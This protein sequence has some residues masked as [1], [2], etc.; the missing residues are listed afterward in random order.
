MVFIKNVARSLLS[1]EQGI[2]PAN[3]EKKRKFNLDEKQL[4]SALVFINYVL[5]LEMKQSNRAAGE[6]ALKGLYKSLP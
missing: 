4:K 6:M 1:A 2:L 5:L 3:P